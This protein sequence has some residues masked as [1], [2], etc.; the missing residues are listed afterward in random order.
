MSRLAATSSFGPVKQ[1][2]AGMLNTGYVEVGP[3]HG[4]PVILYPDLQPD[5]GR[6]RHRGAYDHHR[7]KHD[8]FTPAG[9]GAAY[10][11][12][13]TGSRAGPAAAR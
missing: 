8:P 1:I 5:R 4:Q 9:N 7:R 11:A 6:T 13:F 12:K 2:K 3:A 10:R